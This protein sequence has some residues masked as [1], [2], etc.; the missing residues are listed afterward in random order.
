MDIGWNGYSTKLS[1]NI[2]SCIAFSINGGAPIAGWFT[3]ETPIRMDDWGYTHFTKQP[4]VCFVHI[5][6]Y[7][8]DRIHVW[9]V[10]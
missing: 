4:H 1:F 3:M 7:I 9:Y 2:V 6:I 5:Y 8:S 10:C